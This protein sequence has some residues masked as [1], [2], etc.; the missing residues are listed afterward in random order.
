MFLLFGSKYFLISL[1]CCLIS[2]TFRIFPLFIDF[3]L[4]PIVAMEDTLYNTYL[5]KSIECWFVA[6]VLSILENSLG[7]L[8]RN[9]YAVFVLF[10]FNFWLYFCLSGY[11]VILLLCARRFVWKIQRQRYLPNRVPISFC[12]LNGRRG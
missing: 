4:H 8:Q 5:L 2:T 7:A 11:L 6:Y 12:G 9:V 10:S 1:V 3:Y